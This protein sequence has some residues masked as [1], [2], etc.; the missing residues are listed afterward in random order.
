[1]NN[2]VGIVD[3]GVGNISS[4]QN[5]MS[6]L[7]SNSSVINEPSE[8]LLY[9]KIILP[10][11]GAFG[12]AIKSIKTRGFLGPLNAYYRSGRN[13]LGICL[14][15][16]LM[17]K[18]SEEDGFHTGLGWLDAEV[19]KLEISNDAKIPHIGWNDIKIS[20]KHKLMDNIQDGTDFYFVHSYRVC[21]NN[22]C[23][24]LT[25]SYHGLDFT[26]AIQIENLYGVQFHPEKSQDKG[27]YLLK[28][29][30]ELAHA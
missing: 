19:K 9:E 20:K 3:Y 11:V 6:E 10:G 28:N 24:E 27:L 1:M 12:D 25:K 26:S 30:L 5:A 2:E 14:G 15:M 13:V 18:S 17:C 16:Q 22:K 29:F 4:I 7:G 21:C 23:D 8:L